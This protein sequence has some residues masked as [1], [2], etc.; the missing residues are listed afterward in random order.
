MAKTCPLIGDPCMEHGCEWYQHLVGKNPQT[1]A[2]QDE[3]GCAIKW[4]PLL[5]IENSQQ[6]RQTG[7]AVED[8]RNATVRNNAA[9]VGVIEALTHQIADARREANARR[10]DREPPH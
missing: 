3:W 8:F 4:L 7:A 5:L 2:D 10:L 9:A 1:G 6:Q